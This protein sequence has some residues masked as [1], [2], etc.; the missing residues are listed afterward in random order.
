MSKLTL[1]VVVVVSLLIF[2][3][4]GVA[5]GATILPYPGRPCATDRGTNLDTPID[6]GGGWEV[7]PAGMS[8]VEALAAVDGNRIHTGTTFTGTR[9]EILWFNQIERTGPFRRIEIWVVGYQGDRP[10]MGGCSATV[11][12]RGAQT[13]SSGFGLPPG[14]KYFMGSSSGIRCVT[15]FAPSENPWTQSE[16]NN[17]VLTLI[18]VDNIDYQEIN[19]EKVWV[20]VY[21]T[22]TPYW[23]GECKW[24]RYSADNAA[25]LDVTLSRLEEYDQRYL[26][27]HN[28]FLCAQTDGNYLYVSAGGTGQQNP[29]VSSTFNL[30]RYLTGSDV[31]VSVYALRG[32]SMPDI[33]MIAK[34]TPF[35]QTNPVTVYQGYLGFPGSPPGG[36]PT[37][38]YATRSRTLYDLPGGDLTVTLQ[39]YDSSINNSNFRTMIDKLWATASFSAEISVY[40][41]G[42]S[43]ISGSNYSGTDIWLD[44][45][46]SGATPGA[47]L[48]P[49]IFL[50]D[51]EMASTYL[52]VN[53]S[54]EFPSM[55]PELQID[56]SGWWEGI[57][58]LDTDHRIMDSSPQAQGDLW[59]KFTMGGQDVGNSNLIQGVTLYNKAYVLDDPNLLYG[60]EMADH[61]ES[62]CSDMK[63]SRR[64]SETDDWGMISDLIP[65]YTVFYIYG[66]GGYDEK[67]HET[68]FKDCGGV[69]DVGS[70]L[71]GMAIDALKPRWNYPEYNFV[72]IDACNV[73]NYDDM[74]RAFDI[75]RE[76]GSIRANRAYLGWQGYSVDYWSNANWTRDVWT[77]LRDHACV[78]DAVDYAND[79]HHAEV[80]TG[81]IYGD[82]ATTLFGVYGHPDY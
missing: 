51:T 41:V 39:S 74:A 28:P 4:R 1:F 40:P 33:Y 26:P 68:Y 35:D 17:L 30:G 27:N 75:L 43:N 55:Q 57:I 78:G 29:P 18:G 12:L 16:I 50:G 71:V 10:D 70:G 72:H 20:R 13:S 54:P 44:T 3:S 15:Y 9:N 76:D 22:D 63:H 73:A 37:P 25:P 69:E 65:T 59:V 77:Q 32:R 24:K 5:I 14:L 21:E 61:V 49:S 7:Y 23:R 67:E 45:R 36:P 79:Q 46:I 58:N 6:S 60:S 62:M 82:E 48:V 11:N 56:S 52:H 19:L 38:S 42:N 66:H 47:L 81:R 64:G 80:G 31:T 8:H 53:V 34:V 2:V